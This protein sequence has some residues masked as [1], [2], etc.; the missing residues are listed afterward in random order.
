MKIFARTVIVTTQRGFTSQTA[1]RRPQA[2]NGG[3]TPAKRGAESTGVVNRTMVGQG[4]L[5]V[6]E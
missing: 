6:L 3:F 1:I 2:E 4:L 5:Q